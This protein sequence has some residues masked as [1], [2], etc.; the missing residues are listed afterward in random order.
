LCHE[1]AHCSLGHLSGNASPQKE[2]E[3]DE[4]AAHY[5]LKLIEAGTQIKTIRIDPKLAGGPL[6]LMR[7]FEL[8][9]RNKAKLTGTTPKHDTHPAPGERAKP[10][11]RVLAPHMVEKA[12]YILDGLEITL[13]DFA[14]NLEI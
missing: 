12:T 7:F 8:H 9:A 3:A 2:F 6:L 14:R 1:L 13:G 4:L 5:F 10:I 11:R